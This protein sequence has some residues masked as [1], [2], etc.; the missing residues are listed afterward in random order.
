MRPSRS[1]TYLPRPL[2]RIE[3]GTYLPI[4]IGVSL[5]ADPLSGK[6]VEPRVGFAGPPART[7]AGFAQLAARRGTRAGG[8]PAEFAVGLELRVCGN[9]KDEE[10]CGNGK[11]VEH[12]H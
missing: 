8:A 11:D 10:H 4:K 12:A 2:S 7:A 3:Q 1:L 6:E 5:T 9:G